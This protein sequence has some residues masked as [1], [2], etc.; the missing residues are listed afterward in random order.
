ME[1]ID[2]VEEKI[3]VFVHYQEVFKISPYDFGYLKTVRD[4]CN[5]RVHVWSKLD[6]FRSGVAK[7][8]GV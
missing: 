3:R 2:A 6:A 5:D 1:N 7:V 8:C 4:C